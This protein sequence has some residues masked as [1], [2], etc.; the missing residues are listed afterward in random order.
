M[1][2]DAMSPTSRWKVGRVCIDQFLSAERKATQV[3]Y[4]V[5][6]DEL[7]EPTGFR[8]PGRNELFVKI[9]PDTSEGGLFVPEDSTPS[10][11]WFDVSVVRRHQIDDLL[12]AFSFSAGVS[13]DKI[14]VESDDDVKENL[15]G[16]VQRCH[17]HL[18]KFGNRHC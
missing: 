15:A 11:I 3:S 13:H 16:L 4:R 7:T 5:T 17:S 14:I 10:Q 2:I 12:I 8:S 9:N 1:T 18:H 6:M